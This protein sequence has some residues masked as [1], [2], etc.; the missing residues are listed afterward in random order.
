MPS[1]IIGALRRA[2]GQVGVAVEVGVRAHAV[3]IVPVVPAVPVPMAMVEGV[4]MGVPVVD[5]G[6]G[7]A[8][9][10]LVQ[11]RKLC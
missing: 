8:V 1:N 4:V 9:L 7:R 2:S 11:R 6:H 5:V 3:T 10:V